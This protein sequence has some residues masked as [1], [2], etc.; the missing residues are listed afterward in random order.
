MSVQLSNLWVVLQVLK[1]LNQ[2]HQIRES[3]LE[4]IS[5]ESDAQSRKR[6]STPIVVKAV[7]AC[8]IEDYF[9]RYCMLINSLTLWPCFECISAFLAPVICKVT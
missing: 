5:F 8:E 9:P 2:L 7:E 4:Y 1:Q 3:K 6:L